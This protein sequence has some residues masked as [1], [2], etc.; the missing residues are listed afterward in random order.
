M[1]LGQTHPDR[2]ERIGLM[3][4]AGTIPNGANAA[5][6]VWATYPGLR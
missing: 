3:F 4:V 1:P 2:D 5:L 6:I